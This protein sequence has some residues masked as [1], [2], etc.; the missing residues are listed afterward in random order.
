MV[1]IRDASGRVL[2]RATYDRDGNEV[3]LIDDMAPERPIDVTTLPRPRE[4]R[5]TIS[6]RD[7]N[8][9]LK[10]KVGGPSLSLAMCI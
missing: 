2:R 5:V 8:A 6:T 10:A 7:E 4:D 3:I 1:T 9:A